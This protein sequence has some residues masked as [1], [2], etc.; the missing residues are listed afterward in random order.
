MLN[1]IESIFS[2]TLRCFPNTLVALSDRSIS[3]K[4]KNTFRQIKIANQ[5]FQFFLKL[6]IQLQSECISYYTVTRLYVQNESVKYI[7]EIYM[8]VYICVCV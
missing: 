8:Y 6:Y 7:S 1:S 3:W 2:A 5:R 4:W